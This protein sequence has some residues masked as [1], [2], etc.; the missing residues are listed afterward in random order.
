V[1]TDVRSEAPFSDLPALVMH[2]SNSIS[3]DRCES[4]SYDVVHM[5]LG[6]DVPESLSELPHRHFV[7]LSVGQSYGPFP[8]ENFDATRAGPLLQI[9][10]RLHLQS[11]AGFLETFSPLCALELV[12]RAAA[13][14]TDR[15]WE[16]VRFRQLNVESQISRGDLLVESVVECRIQ[17]DSFLP[18]A[19][20]VIGRN[21]DRK[22]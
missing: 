11:L 13:Y 10:T 5:V 12:I 7:D 19:C 18:E 21:S 16:R 3:I 22:R 9:P 17:T 15:R 20:S 4:S 8:S 2:D 6:L 14:A 1:L